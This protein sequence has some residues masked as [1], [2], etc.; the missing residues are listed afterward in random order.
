MRRVQ[1]N[2]KGEIVNDEIYN[3]RYEVLEA[4]GFRGDGS[5]SHDEIRA[6]RSTEHANI[7]ER[8]EN[9]VSGEDVRN[10][11]RAV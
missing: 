11:F 9:F 8:F 4:A 2:R 7:L 3:A 10:V 6:G 1:W 5:L